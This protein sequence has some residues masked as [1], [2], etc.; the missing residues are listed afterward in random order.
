MRGLIGFWSV[1]EDKE[2]GEK[3]DEMG[4]GQVGGGGLDGLD[5]PGM[6]CTIHK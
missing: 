5:W 6:R 1:S 4:C 2:E 3:V